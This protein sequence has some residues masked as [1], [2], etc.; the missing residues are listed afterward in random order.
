[1][2]AA[3]AQT[4]VVLATLNAK[5]IHAS[6]GLRC[7]RAN[8][9]AWRERSVIREFTINDRP[10]DVVESILAHQ[11]KVVGLGVYVWNATLMLTVVRL[12]KQVAPRV[13][14]VIGGP[15][16]S[17]ELDQQEIVRLADHVVTGEGERAFAELVEATLSGRK[18]LTKVLA[19][20]L[21]DLETTALAYE[22]YTDEDI[23]HRVIYV[24]ASRGCPF[25][26]EFCL[27]SLDTK[28]RNIPLPTLLAALDKLITRGVRAL[29]FVDRTFNLSPKISN[30][31][32]DFVLARQQLGVF[33]HFEMIPDRFPEA[34]RTRIAEFPDG[35]I[36]LEVGIQT[37][38][39]ETSAR[40]SRKQDY[41]AIATNLTFLREHTGAH[42]HADL[43]VGLPGE[44]E[45]S[46]A[47]GFD[48]LIK[49]G[50][51]EIQVGVLKRL[52]GTPIDR[53]DADW[54][55]QWSAEPPYEIVQNK[56]LSFETLQRMKRFARVWDLVA[57]RGN[58][59]RSV[60]LLWGNGS[61]YDGIAQ[62]A[63]WLAARTSLGAV[64]LP[65]LAGFMLTYLVDVRGMERDVVGAK[66][67]VDFVAPGRRV[68]DSL[69]PYIGQAQRDARN[70][71][72]SLP[73]RQA[74]HQHGKEA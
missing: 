68:P 36:Q 67:A 14:V 51:E 33:A 71:A 13:V 9:G 50:P 40:I 55:V 54:A 65:R 6:F 47:R 35:A 44:D 74:R 12:L 23:A 7:L 16:V 22:E 69:A 21:P 5:Y 20:G 42:V 58:F 60:S 70:A 49:L 11:P 72:K 43:I 19:G 30:A 8:L 18:F 28:V 34:L 39:P 73:A 46:F 32:L 56:L 38:D 3:A 26:C 31:L 10:V 24:E 66:L 17:H 41:D 57:N 45:T 37:F 53:H 4:D 52:R 27:S 64:G 25:S 48:T 2:N 61:P 15:E 62:F 63:E 1:M 59:P 29:K